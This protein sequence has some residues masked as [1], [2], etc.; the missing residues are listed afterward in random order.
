M[1]ALKLL[2]LFWEYGNEA[3]EKL[4]VRVFVRRVHYERRNRLQEAWRAG[5][6]PKVQ[7]WHGGI[8]S[9]GVYV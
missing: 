7:C 3:T 2:P 9:M 6:G 1:P 5:T 4:G 8:Y